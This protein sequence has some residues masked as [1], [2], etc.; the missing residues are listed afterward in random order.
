VSRAARCLANNGGKLLF[1]HRIG[2]PAGKRLDVIFKNISLS[3][4]RVA[5]YHPKAKR[6]PAKTADFIAFLT[7]SLR[8]PENG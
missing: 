1:P 3:P 5:A 2:I 6:L 4:E 7:H 8:P